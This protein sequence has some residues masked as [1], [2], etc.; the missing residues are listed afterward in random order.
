MRKIPKPGTDEFPAYAA[1]YIDLLPDDGSVLEELVRNI[2]TTKRLVSS[3]A[4]ER[5]A[6]RYAPGKWTI[7]DIVAHLAD[8]ERV[9]AYRALRFARGDATELPGFD[10]E[11]F[12]R[13]SNANDRPIDELLRELAAVRAATVLLF[14]RFPEDAL[15]RSGIA[16]G[17]RTSVRAIAYH[18]AGHELR[19]VRIIRERYL[20]LPDQNSN[21]P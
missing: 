7:K 3:V 9:Y 14:E 16:D 6:Y 19:H 15:L 18:L 5:L 4:P 12:A 13:G 11:A 10:Q 1:M 20:K 2:E 21:R 8:D 17:S